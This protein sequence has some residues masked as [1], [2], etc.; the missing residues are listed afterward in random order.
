MIPLNCLKSNGI[1]VTWIQVANA[2]SAPGEI[3]ER[4]M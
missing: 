4:N 2:I 3:L 1:S